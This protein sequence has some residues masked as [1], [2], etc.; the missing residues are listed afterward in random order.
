MLFFC[1]AESLRGQSF[2]CQILN[3]H[4]LISVRWTGL[5]DRSVINPLHLYLHP[6]SALNPA[7]LLVPSSEMEMS[8]VN[9]L[10]HLA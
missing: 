3:G 2:R 1:G 10:L 7:A 8:Q 4:W 9:Y 5:T 6:A